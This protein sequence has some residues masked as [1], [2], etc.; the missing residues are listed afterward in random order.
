ML[1]SYYKLTAERE[2]MGI[3]GLPL[4]AEETKELTELLEKPKNDLAQS[5]LRGELL[6]WNRK[7]LRPQQELLTRKDV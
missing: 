5:F 2:K 7:E 4:N 1:N 3:P 6:W